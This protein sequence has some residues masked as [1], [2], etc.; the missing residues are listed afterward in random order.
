MGLER[1]TQV[2][3]PDKIMWN[4]LGLDQDPRDIEE[5]PVWGSQRE[6]SEPHPEELG[7]REEHSRRNH[8]TVES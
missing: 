5:W 1:E 3:N 7:R 8:S 6:I 4:G 2:E